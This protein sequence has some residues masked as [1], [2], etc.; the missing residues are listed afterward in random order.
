MTIDAE[1]RDEFASLG[2]AI[3]DDL[4]GNEEADVFKV[5]DINAKAIK[6][7]LA[8]T[9]QWR[10]LNVSGGLERGRL[11][12]LG[13][14]YSAVDVVSPVSASTATRSS[15][16]CASWKRP[17]SPP[18]TRWRREPMNQFVI[19]MKLEGDATGLERAASTGKAA[20][21]GLGKEAGQAGAALDGYSASLE[22]SAASARHAAQAAEQAQTQ[23]RNLR[24]SIDSALGIGQSDGRSTVQAAQDIAVYGHSLD[25]LRAKYNPV[26]AASKR[27]EAELA[28]L[29]EALK[30]GAIS[31]QEHGAALEALNGR[32]TLATRASM[33][34]ET[35]T[36]G[37]TR[38]FGLNRIGMM[39]LRAAGVNTFQALAAGMDPFQVAMME[40]SQVVGAFVQGTEGGLLQAAKNIGSGFKAATV[41]IATAIGIVP[42]IGIALAAAGTAGYIAFEAITNSVKSA[43]EILKEH[44]AWV[45][46]IAAAYPQAAEAA[47]KYDEEAKKLPRSVASADAADLASDNQKAYQEA[48]ASLLSFIRLAETQTGQIGKSGVDA[49]KQ[50]EAQIVSGKVDAEKLAAIVGEWRLNQDFKD[51]M[52]D[53][54]K[55]IQDTALKAAQLQQSLKGVNAAAATLSSGRMSMADVDKMLA[56]QDQQAATLYRLKQQQAASIGA[57]GARSPQEKAA[58]ARASVLAEPANGNDSEAVRQYRADAAATL[59]YAQAEDAL[60]EAQASRTRALDRTIAEEKMNLALVGQSVAASEAMKMQFQLMSQLEEEAARN[61]T[62]VSKAEIETIKQKAAEY[63]R[64][65]AAEQAA[66]AIHGQQTSLELAKAELSLVGQSQA[67]HDQV[68]AELK[69]EQEIRQLGIDAT[70]AQAQQIRRLAQEQAAYNSELQRSKAGFD[71]IRQTGTNAID[72]LIGA[73]SKGST[74]F[75]SLAVSIGQD[76]A[77]TG[78][79]LSLGNPLKNSLYGTNLPTMQ[80]VG[81]I[82]GF[83]KTLLGGG[84][85]GVGQ[86]GSPNNPMYVT[87]AG[88]GG[89][90]GLL[91]NQAGNDPWAGL[92]SL[93]GANDNGGAGGASPV[94]GGG[95]AGQIWNFFSGKGLQPHQ[96]AGILGNVSQESSFNPLAIGDNLT[97]GGLFQDHGS[98]FT[99]L[100]SFI[101]GR[102]NLGNV[103]GQLENAWRELQG[104]ESGVL[105][106]LLAAPDVRSATAAFAGF[107]RPAGFSLGGSP[108]LM[109]G[110]TNRLSAASDA[111]TK[112]GGSAGSA[113]SSLTSLGTNAVSSLSDAASTATQGLGKFGNSLMNWFPAAPG[114]G[115]GLGNLFGSLLG[116]GINQSLVAASPQ[117]ASLISTRSRRALRRRRL[118]RPRRRHLGRRPGARPGIRLRCAGD[119]G[120]RRRQSR[121][122]PPQHAARLC[123]RRLW[124]G[125]RRGDGRAAAVVGEGR[126][127]RE[128]QHSDGRKRYQ[129]AEDR[130]P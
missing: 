76:I 107:E 55:T 69:A 29:D 53:L 88:A 56:Y 23:E 22:K 93:A 57:I 32:Y 129:P 3:P 1:M 63:G 103:Q 50:L 84:A 119:E 37:L 17:R 28:G 36:A 58:A 20:I 18:S 52:H 82:G 81:G 46:Q 130:A 11:M 109:S 79:E 48:M 116:G 122:A 31:A 127:G 89:L 21:D 33:Q 2:V 62:E 51:G 94:S 49:L 42:S 96:I 27:Y 35:A 12:W 101:G 71:D 73:L 105:S 10:V 24:A 72:S 75:K 80:D 110:W 14:D 34:M 60:K 19:G 104:P 13:L 120:D 5:W 87:F 125:A 9:T 38:S 7:F 98:R 113:T 78:L 25:E 59:A 86:R 77:K 26:F 44:K 70:G 8:L 74:D 68:I 4:V 100:L 45:D 102:G 64:L 43:D 123:H 30:L 108:E 83:F 114:G 124:P 115:G 61:H 126:Q 54:A 40:G 47:R 117:A 39:E 111:L 92:R 6:A 91:G 95:V 67:V 99:N 16:T 90:G 112:F 106:R 85:A 15:A 65:A 118:H 121:G 41:S 128:R 66:Q 97:S